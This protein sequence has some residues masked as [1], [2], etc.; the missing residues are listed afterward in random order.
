MVVSLI[1][2]TPE[3]SIPLNGILVQWPIKDGPIPDAQVLDAL[4][5]FVDVT[6]QLGATVYVHCEAG[7]NRSA[8]VVGRVLMVRGMNGAEAVARVRARRLGSLGDEYADWLL[9]H[10]IVPVE[11]RTP[12]PQAAQPP[13]G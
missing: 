4:A 6:L 1:T 3:R 10:P 12:G 13:H 2:A 11:G 7:M 5:S 8:L 9:S